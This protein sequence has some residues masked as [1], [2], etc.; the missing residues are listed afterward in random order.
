MEH[1]LHKTRMELEVNQCKNRELVESYNAQ[2]TLI[3]KQK[4]NEACLEKR[5]SKT[6]C[7]NEAI[8]FM[9]KQWSNKYVQLD[10]D[11]LM[12][13]GTE[14]HQCSCHENVM[15]IL[16]ASLGT[17]YF[18]YIVCLSTYLEAICFFYI[19]QNM[20]IKMKQGCWL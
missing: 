10:K 18:Y 6:Q 4:R 19:N 13:A 2:R 1:E 17:C 7:K 8:N 16:C 3:D 5:C 12:N 14:K 20:H 11:E 9:Q 15:E